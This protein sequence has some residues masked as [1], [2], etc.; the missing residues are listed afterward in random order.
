MTHRN[1][2]QSQSAKPY[3]KWAINIIFLVLVTMLML[4][5][6]EG[7]MRWLDGYELSTLELNQNP[8][9]VQPTE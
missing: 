8:A 1:P 5:L 3:K 7:A 2:S 9:A 6:A 4:A